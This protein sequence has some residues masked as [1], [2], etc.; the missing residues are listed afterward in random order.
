MKK[1]KPI[2]KKNIILMF[3]LVIF[4]LISLTLIEVL[5]S[6]YDKPGIKIGESFLLTDKNNT[7]FDSTSH[8]TNKLV[9]FGY[10]YCPDI[11]PFDILKLSN[12]IDENPKIIKSLKFIF[13]TVDPERDKPD[14][15]KS[16]LENFNP[17][18][19]GLTGSKKEIEKV[20]NNFRV[21]VK[22][23]K[24]SLKDENYL[25]DH[26]SLFFLIDQNDNY[27]AHF[28]PSDFNSKI[29]SYF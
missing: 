10:T 28:R 12:F 27:I 17:A 3:S 24:N 22:K 11:C 21:Y 7:V 26:S 6:K 25:I 20:T 23:N 9:Y 13:I 14:Q 16:F 1:Y 8:K 15:L 18:I 19:I 29:K 2:L 4:I 5:K